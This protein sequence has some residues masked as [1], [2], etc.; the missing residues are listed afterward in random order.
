M[1][2]AN[3]K[4]QI[5]NGKIFHFSFCILPF[6][7]AI[8]GCT[9]FHVGS[10]I[11]QGRRALR[12]GDPKVALA[13]FQ[14]AAEMDPDYLLDFSLLDQGVWTY[15]GRA[16]YATGNLPEA[17]KALEGARSRYGRDHLAKL[18]LGIVQARD[19]DREKG[20]KEIESGLKGLG[21][22]LDYLEINR[23]DGR[24]WDPG[25]SLISEIQ[26]DLAM[27]SR[28]DVNWPALIA[29]GE[30]LGREFEEE[31]ERVKADKRRDRVG[32]PAGDER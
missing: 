7:L 3:F 30:W 6:A 9:A 4:L 20:L 32:A 1:K 26:K 19:G 28:K 13:H 12:Y 25:K 16:H 24:F 23:N 8:S 29:S 5:G 17:R 14:R 27:I 31:V 18:Y 22:W 10:E 21:D 2:I 15:V 11:Q